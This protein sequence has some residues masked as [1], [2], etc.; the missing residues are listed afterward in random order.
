MFFLTF[1]SF[2]IYWFFLG[3]IRSCMMLAIFFVINICIFLSYLHFGKYYSVYTKNVN[4][5]WCLFAAFTRICVFFYFSLPNKLF[6][7]LLNLKPYKISSYFVLKIVV[8][9]TSMA[10]SFEKIGEISDKKELWKFVVKVYHKLTIVSNN[11]EHL[12]LIFVDAEVSVLYSGFC[13]VFNCFRHLCFLSSSIKVPLI[14]VFNVFVGD[15]YS[16]SCANRNESNI[17][18]GVTSKQ[19]LQILWFS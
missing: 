3:V 13:C 8:G 15:G 2:F 9:I 4:L 14:C 1:S 7:S 12:K 18:F 5:H 17:W 19:H 16:C 10:M 6:F 11:K